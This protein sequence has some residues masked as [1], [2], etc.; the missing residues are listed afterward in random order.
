MAGHA[1][2]SVPLP[3]LHISALIGI[4]ESYSISWYQVWKVTGSTKNASMNEDCI[5]GDQ[6][7]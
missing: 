6:S 5:A 1:V 4:Y 3:V 2:E 7:L